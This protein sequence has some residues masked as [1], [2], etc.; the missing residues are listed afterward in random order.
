M[1]PFPHFFCFQHTIVLSIFLFHLIPQLLLIKL[2]HGNIY[3]HTQ[4]NNEKDLL[5]QVGIPR[6]SAALIISLR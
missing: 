1:C 4:Q 5:C 6:E 2:E 3:P